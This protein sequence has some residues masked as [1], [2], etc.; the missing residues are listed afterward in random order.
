MKTTSA[1]SQTL[2]TTPIIKKH[3]V[4]SWSSDDYDDDTTGDDKDT[5]NPY[6]LPKIEDDSDS[7]ETYPLNKYEETQSMWNS[8]SP[9][10]WASNMEFEKNLSTTK[11][12]FLPSEQRQPEKWSRIV[13]GTFLVIALGLII[14][15]IVRNMRSRNKR[16]NYEEVQSLVV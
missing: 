5:S 6:A 11:T 3:V 12:P 2:K 16:K 8:S 14:A 4:S 1:K 7:N 15:T 13:G 10:P 9:V